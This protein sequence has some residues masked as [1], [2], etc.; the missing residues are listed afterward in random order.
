MHVV[1]V[2][3][4]AMFKRYFD[5]CINKWDLTHAQVDRLVRTRWAEGPF[6]APHSPNVILILAVEI[7]GG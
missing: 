7:L 4:M 3:T 5:R 2:D 6:P 1:E